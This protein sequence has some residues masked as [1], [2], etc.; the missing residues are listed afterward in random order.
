MA[1]REAASAVLGNP[2]RENERAGIIVNNSR[3]PER[4]IRENLIL[5]DLNPLV[6]IFPPSSFPTKQHFIHRL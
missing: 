4:L 1:W 5:D 3:V 6:S 2:G